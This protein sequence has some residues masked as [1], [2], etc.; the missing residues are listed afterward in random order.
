MVISLC[1]LFSVMCGVDASVRGLRVCNL[2]SSHYFRLFCAA[3]ES[4]SISAHVTMDVF[5][6][7]CSPN[8]L[9]DA[10]MPTL[11]DAQKI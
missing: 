2:F 1:S 8:D 10:I 6:E 7:V 9:V 11:S 3:Q 5:A 4:R